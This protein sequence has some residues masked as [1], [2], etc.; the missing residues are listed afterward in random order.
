[1]RKAGV[2]PLA[3][4]Y[5]SVGDYGIDDTVV[6]TALSE[7]LR[8]DVGDYGV[9]DYTAPPDV[10][11]MVNQAAQASLSAKAAQAARNKQPAT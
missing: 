8:N 5:A 9:S 2:N 10:L 4:E 7:A 6:G 11:G 3:E 1:M